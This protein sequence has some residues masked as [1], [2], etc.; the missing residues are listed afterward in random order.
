M[1]FDIG[2]NDEQ[3]TW[4]DYPGGEHERYCIRPL[5]PDKSRHFAKLTTRKVRDRSGQEIEKTD[6]ERHREL[7]YDYLLEAWEGVTANGQP[8][9]C[10]LENK[11]KLAGMSGKRANWIVDMAVD[12]ANDEAQ[13]QTQEQETFR[14]LGETAARR[15][16]ADV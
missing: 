4:I 7:L 14:S 9:P 1:P 15:T 11:L 6:D 13:R 3:G 2:R 16:M 12:L 5:T 10:N 8:V